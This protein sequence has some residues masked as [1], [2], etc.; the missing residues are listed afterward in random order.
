MHVIL[1][2]KQK[3]EG[4]SLKRADFTVLANIRRKKKIKSHEMFDAKV[5]QGSSLPGKEK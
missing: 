1:H 3:N 2:E 4:F 5:L